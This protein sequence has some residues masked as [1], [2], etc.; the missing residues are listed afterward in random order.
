MGGWNVARDY[1]AEK[2]LTGKVIRIF[3]TPR[4]DWTAGILQCREG[5]PLANQCRFRMNGKVEL[6]DQI[7]ASGNWVSDPKWGMQFAIESIQYPTPDLSSDGL[8]EYLSREK[9]FKKIGPVKAQ[10]IADTFGDNF[11][12][13]LRNN[14]ERIASAAK[15]NIEDVLLIQEKWCERSDI[16][17]ISVWLAGFGVTPGQIK[18]IAK[19]YGNMAK[20]IIE[21]NPYCLSETIDGIGFLTNDQIALK[22]GIDPNCSARLRAGIQYIINDLHEQ[23]GHTYVPL[24]SLVRE[25]IKKLYLESLDSAERLHTE[26][27]YLVTA[28]DLAEVVLSEGNFIGAAWLQAKELYILE[29]LQDTSPPSEASWIFDWKPGD[30]ETLTGEQK[31]AVLNSVKHKISVITGGAGTGKSYTIKSII[32]ALRANDKV[33]AICTPTGK[34][35]RRLQS[36]GIPAQTI[37]RTLEYNPFKG[38]FSYTKDEPLPV[39]V[40]IVDEVSMCSVPLLWDLF[41]AITQ[42]SRIILV[43]DH[44]QLPPIGPGNTLKDICDYS[45][46]PITYLTKCHR[47]AG[48]L[49][50][51]CSAT[52]KGTLPKETIDV[53]PEILPEAYKNLNEYTPQWS[54]IQTWD[55]Y[56]ETMGLLHLLYESQLQEWGFDPLMDV[57]V[58][59][60]QRPGPLGVDRI[61][62]ELQRITQF[63]R[64]IMV[65][66][67]EGKAKPKFLIGDKVMQIRNNYGFPHGLMN[68]TQGVILSEITVDEKCGLRYECPQ[69]PLYRCTNCNHC[70]N[71]DSI[72]SHLLI[73]FDDRDEPL[74][75]NMNNGELDDITL[76]YAVTV[77]KVQGSQYPCTIVICS[78]A[79]TYMLSRN[80]I[81]T[82]VTRS[83]ISCIVL[84]DK[85]GMQR[86]V[87]TLKDMSRNT[88]TALYYQD[89]NDSGMLIEGEK[90]EVVY[91]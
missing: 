66:P 81:Y 23:G 56:A 29:R 63:K 27:E 40:V 69:D 19:K 72:V 31:H 39:D 43:G 71:Q 73:N 85:L 13:I 90:K 22:M 86:A 59:S 42:T 30:P 7:T 65:E 46:V 57:Q 62:I 28:G 18:K 1:D 35:A 82:A 80:L 41:Q 26:I 9:D 12:D 84:G 88:W 3:G 76:A 32:E 77:H 50:Q 4:E 48:K 47:N 5:D 6:Q 68:G 38:G 75:I 55:D 17:A 49:K 37:H 61:N 33:I 20:S 53:D 91:A 79:H 11:D 51:N 16:N 2:C 24:G 36:D 25:A 44:N 67:P 60:P 54:V 45:I 14:P 58:I 34:A 52:L 70:K 83:Q 15:I 89:K 74:C 21:A 64:G 8:A 78:K 87:S 10:I